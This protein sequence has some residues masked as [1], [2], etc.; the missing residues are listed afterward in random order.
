MAS[1]RYF[2]FLHGVISLYCVAFFVILSFRMALFSLLPR[3]NA[4]QKDK[5]MKKRNAKRWNNEKTPSEKT[6]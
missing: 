6:K 1:F 4:K 2:I 3:Q 5:K